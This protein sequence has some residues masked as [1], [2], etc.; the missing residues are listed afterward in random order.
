MKEKIAK[1]DWAIKKGLQMVQDMNDEV[2]KEDSKQE[3]QTESESTSDEKKPP[4]KHW[5]GVQMEAPQ[6]QG[7]QTN[8]EFCQPV[9]TFDEVQH[10][11]TTKEGNLF[12]PPEEEH[13]L[14][15]IL[16]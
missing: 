15:P 11:N 1:S 4:R 5:T 14:E 16:S 13:A 9:E 10:L 2:N 6:S 8:F 7:F 12:I 3:E